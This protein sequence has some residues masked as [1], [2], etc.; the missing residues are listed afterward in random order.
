M[1]VETVVAATGTTEIE[2]SEKELQGMILRAG[3]RPRKR[4]SDYV[5]LDT[6]ADYGILAAPVPS[7]SE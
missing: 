4:D 7:Q 2:A 5:S 6:Q 3:F 1:M